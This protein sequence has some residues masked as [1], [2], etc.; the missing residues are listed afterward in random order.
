MLDVL[1]MCAP[2]IFLVLVSLRQC[3]RKHAS[4]LV[5]AR[6]VVVAKR[7][8]KAAKR[9]LKAR[10]WRSARFQLQLGDFEPWFH[11]IVLIIDS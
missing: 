3:F 7:T 1:D 8:Q 9:V 10:V 6:F 4:K 2:S 11:S 5:L